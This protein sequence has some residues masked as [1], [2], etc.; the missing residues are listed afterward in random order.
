MSDT[1]LK[2]LLGEREEMVLA[3][4]QH[5]SLL[6]QTTLPEVALIILSIILV[7]MLWA[8]MLGTPLSAGHLGLALMAISSPSRS[9][10]GHE[11]S[12]C[13]PRPAAAG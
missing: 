10:P 11:F 6:V 12:T 2:S 4:R 13:S 8:G 9:F 1:Y 7:T 5:W 3:A